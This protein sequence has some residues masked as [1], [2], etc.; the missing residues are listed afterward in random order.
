MKKQQGISLVEMLVVALV[1]AL[2]VALI[3]ANY[4]D[5]VYAERRSIAQQALMTAVSLQE[6]WHLRLYEYA[7]DIREVGGENAAG[8]HYILSVTQNPCGDTS[9]FTI[10]ATA[11]GEQLDDTKCQKMSVN[12]LGQ[13]RA[14]DY[15]NQDTTSE[16][17][18]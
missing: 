1:V 13:R 3:Y 11:I 18:D 10:I 15:Y 6:R 2:I 5:A 17:W 9:C 7:R 14:V 16:C 4:R 12:Y 8:E